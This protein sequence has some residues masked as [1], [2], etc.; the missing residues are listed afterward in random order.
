[1]TA[2][3][4]RKTAAEAKF[5]HD[6]EFQFKTMARRNNVAPPPRS[7][8]RPARQARPQA[9]PTRGPP[10]AAV[11]NRVVSSSPGADLADEIF[12]QL[13]NLP[14]LPTNEAWRD[15]VRQELGD[16]PVDVEKLR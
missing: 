11:R 14:M 13:R 5:T 10:P 15:D 7:P 2:F 8:L 1:M 12:D 3:D 16:V 4:D 9:P 6:Q